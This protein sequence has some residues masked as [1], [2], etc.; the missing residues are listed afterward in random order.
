MKVIYGEAGAL[1]LIPV[2]VCVL[3]HERVPLPV[4]CIAERREPYFSGT[5]SKLNRGTAVNIKCLG[6][7]CW[8]GDKVLHKAEEKFTFLK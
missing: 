2:W 3:F 7:F 8:H 6:V 5:T 4:S 1:F